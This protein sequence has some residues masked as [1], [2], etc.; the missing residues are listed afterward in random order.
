VG[1]DLEKAARDAIALYQQLLKNTRCKS[2][3]Q[4][5]SMSRLRELGQVEEAMTVMNRIVTEHPDSKYFDEVEFRSGEYFFTRK[6]FLD[7]EDAY[8]AITDR[9]ARSSFYELALYKLGWTF[10]KQ[11]LYED[12]LNRFIAVLD[13]KQSTGFDFESSRDELEKKR[14]EDTIASSASASTRRLA[15]STIISQSVAISPMRWTSIAIWV[16]S[17]LKNAATTTPP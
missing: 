16:S 5:P 10:Y 8:K 1:A 14:V 13:Y 7:A 11:E 4:V 15:R 12:A 2:K 17:I 3:D 6:K 9:G